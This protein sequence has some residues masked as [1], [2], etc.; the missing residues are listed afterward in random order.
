MGNERFLGNTEGGM[1]VRKKV[2]TH[3]AESLGH[4]TAHVGAL[5]QREKL[6]RG[7]STAFEKAVISSRSSG[8][9]ITL[10]LSSLS[11]LT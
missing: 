2:R 8:K 3:G 5:F 7:V 10:A 6:T 1:L 9:A 4:G 11:L